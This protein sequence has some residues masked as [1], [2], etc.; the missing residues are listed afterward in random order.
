MNS[1]KHIEVKLQELAR[2][3]SEITFFYEFDEVNETHIVEV[4]PLSVYESNNSYK[5]AEGDLTFDFDK[6]F[7]PEDIMFVSENSLTRV[8]K[9]QKVFKNGSQSFSEEFEITESE[10]FDFSTNIQEISV[11]SEKSSSIQG[12]NFALA[13]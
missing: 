7:F 10:V 9:P 12:N 11:L 8:T 5:E 13:A 2:K 4:L 1:K 3:F 6:M